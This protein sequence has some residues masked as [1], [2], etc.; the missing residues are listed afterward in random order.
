MIENFFPGKSYKIILH[1]KLRIVEIKQYKAEHNNNYPKD[2]I[3]CI[4][5]VISILF[6]IPNYNQFDYDYQLYPFFTYHDFSKYIIRKYDKK[7]ENYRIH[8]RMKH[9]QNK[10]TYKVINEIDEMYMNFN[11]YGLRGISNKSTSTCSS[12]FT[13]SSNSISPRSILR[14]TSARDKT[15]QCS[16]SQIPIS[17]HE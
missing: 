11:S 13:N 10:T 16:L 8:F 7:I 12:S 5:K 14:N 3:T 6:N 4:D 15:M 1:R 9:L 17:P 2:N